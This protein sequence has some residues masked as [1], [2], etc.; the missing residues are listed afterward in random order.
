MTATEVY[1][2]LNKNEASVSIKSSMY[3]SH[4]FGMNGPIVAMGKTT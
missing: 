1:V 2:K 3:Y 4:S